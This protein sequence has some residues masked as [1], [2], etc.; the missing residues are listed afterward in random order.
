MGKRTVAQWWL[1]LP[2]YPPRD[3][4]PELDREH[5]I[6][7]P[8]D[9]QPIDPA[10]IWA[11]R[12]IG[13][14]VQIP[15][16]EQLCDF[17][18]FLKFP[19]GRGEEAYLAALKK[20]VDFYARMPYV[21]DSL[22]GAL[23]IGGGTPTVLSAGNLSDL[24]DH[25]KARL[26]FSE[27]AGIE[28]EVHP[29][30]ADREKLQTLRKKGVTRVSFGV[31][32]FDN[33]MLRLLG[34]PHQANDAYRAIELAQEV[35]FPKVGLDLLFGKPGETVANLIADIEA[36][37]K[38]NL[39]SISCYR[40]RVVPHTSIA[41]RAAKLKLLNRHEMYEHW[42]AAVKSLTS[43]GY[44]QYGATDFAR[45][46]GES[47]YYYGF[48]RAPQRETLSFGVGC[49]S[50]VK[51]HVYVN[52]HNLKDYVETINSDR[53][54]VL[55]GKQLTAAE[56]MS[57]YVVLGARAMQVSKSRFTEL[58]GFSMEDMYPDQL[59]L[60]TKQGLIVNGDEMLRLTTPLGAFYINNVCKHFFTPNNWGKPQPLRFELINVE[61]P[62]LT[63]ESVLRFCG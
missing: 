63:K 20:E 43:G 37:M 54:P 30:T 38:L 59:Q 51:G 45:P 31:Q 18:L 22:I 39:A 57:R 27:D 12:R 35:G 46:G 14:Y 19:S 42:E 3:E 32:S 2:G 29:L 53:L 36:A 15:F 21:Q 44:F 9:L 24:I 5:V 48:C 56:A 52:I 47:Q 60:L 40:L 26:P 6:Y 49:L 16:C 11:K 4:Y 50:Y 1:N 34:A 58:F 17:C 10:A 25:L 41:K 13:C 62:V 55:M 28:M 33:D 8:S 61:T 7:Y 23:Y